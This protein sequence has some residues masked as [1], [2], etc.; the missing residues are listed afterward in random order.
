MFLLTAVA[1]LD[2]LKNPRRRRQSSC[3]QFF[4]CGD[5]FRPLYNFRR[6]VGLEVAASSP[7][8]RSL[9]VAGADS[10][11]ATLVYSSTLVEC[12]SRCSILPHSRE[13]SPPKMRPEITPPPPPPK[14]QTLLFYGAED[15]DD[16]LAAADHHHAAAAAADIVAAVAAFFWKQREMLAYKRTPRPTTRHQF[17]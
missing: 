4:R 1:D 2:R 3:L 7:S 10:F 5:F 9:K 12:S 13:P 15:E 11:Q 17:I 16:I 8:F 6:L 14:P